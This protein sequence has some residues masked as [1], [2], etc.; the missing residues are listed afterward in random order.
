M[1]AEVLQNLDN[2][3]QLEKLYRDNRATFKREFNSVYP[4][5]QENP[6]AQIWNERLNYEGDGISWGAGREVVFVLLAASIAG[7]IAKLPEIFGLQP[8]YFYPRNIAFIVFPLLTIYFA[9]KQKLPATSVA[10]ITLIIVA[11]VIYINLLPRNDRSDTLILACIHLPLLLW[12]VLGFAYVGNAPMSTNR[13][14]D[15]LRYNGDLVVMTTIILLAGGL[16]SAITIGLFS[17]IGLRIENFYMSYIGAWGA[18][19]APIV[20]TYLVQT[21]PHLVNKVSPII[22]KIFTPLVL[23]ML[24]IYLGA[25]VYTGKDPYNNRDFLLIF[26]ILL[27]GVMALIAFSVAES[28]KSAT[29]KFENY[30]LL[31]LSIVTIL[32]NGVALSA[33]VFRISEWGITPNR[34][35]VLGGNVLI[36]FNLLVVAYHLFRTAKDPKE[37][38]SVE[39]SI[40]SFLPMYGLWAAL[41]VFV[42]PL[43]FHFR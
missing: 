2:P 35:A 7:V 9:W 26:N 43:A 28:S 4:S 42:F 17:L 1:K 25:V 6:V 34:L 15:F 40:V 37:I 19:A 24:V 21:N 33:I 38:T 30:L 11:S 23:V 36:L 5:I 22:A 32:V 18:A 10:I 3:R 13:R 16:M 8:D 14:L 31:G 12:A 29:R 20:G 27:I 39:N 41:V